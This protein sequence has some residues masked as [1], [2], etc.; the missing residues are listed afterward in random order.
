MCE[1]VCLRACVCVHVCLYVWACVCVPVCVS[2][3]AHALES[4]IVR[5]VAVMTVGLCLCS[6][7]GHVGWQPNTRLRRRLRASPVQNT[8]VQQSP[9]EWLKRWWST[10]WGPGGQGMLFIRPHRAHERGRK[11][12]LNKKKKARFMKAFLLQKRGGWENG[13]QRQVAIPCPSGPGVTRR[14]YCLNSEVP[15]GFVS[16]CSRWKE[17]GPWRLECS[18]GEEHR[19]DMWKRHLEK[20]SLW[21]R[22]CL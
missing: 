9:L 17:R 15:T 21:K 13:S 1:H 7:A 8:A 10:E 14:R 11:K 18:V 19:H 12:K 20:H 16:G 4:W 3:C 5:T 2:V 22:A 6:L